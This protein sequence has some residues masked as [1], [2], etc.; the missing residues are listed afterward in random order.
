L[1]C[2]YFILG[3]YQEDS[4]FANLNSSKLNSSTSK[5]NNNTKSKAKNQNDILSMYLSKN[6]KPKRKNMPKTIV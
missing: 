2:I 4:K 6:K 3:I 5:I 1:L